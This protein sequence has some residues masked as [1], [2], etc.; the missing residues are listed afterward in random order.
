MLS[1]LVASTRQKALYYVL[2]ALLLAVATPA[3]TAVT[4]PRSRFYLLQPVIYLSQPIPY[5]VAAALWLP[6]R[7]ER[8]R[9]VGLVLA[10]LLFIGA[11]LF[12][13]PVLTGLL[14]TGGDMIA[15][16][17]VLFAIVTTGAVLVATVVGFGVSRI[18]QTRRAGS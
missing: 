3:L 6:W 15:L 17:Y 4:Q 1:R 18:L 2:G 16:G 9:N 10:R 14:P 13:V 12:Y 11:A 7:S 8:A 5:C